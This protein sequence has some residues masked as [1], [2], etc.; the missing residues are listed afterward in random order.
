MQYTRGELRNAEKEFYFMP[1][2]CPTAGH[3]R[4]KSRGEGTWWTWAGKE[5]AHGGQRTDTWWTHTRETQE[6]YGI[7]RQLEA[8]PK[9]TRD[10][11]RAHGG[12]QAD[13]WRTNGKQGLE[14]GLRDT[15]RTQGERTKALDKVWRR[16]QAHSKADTRRKYGGYTWRTKCGDAAKA[17]SRR[18]Q[19]GQ[20][21]THRGQ[22][23]GT[24]PEHIAASPFLLREN[25]HSKLF[26]EW[27]QSGG[28]FPN[29]LDFIYFPK[30]DNTILQEL[31]KLCLARSA[32]DNSQS[33]NKL[34]GCCRIV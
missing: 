10:T 23:P 25:P 17:E 26:G 29:L 33:S 5:W 9:R 12:H 11:R 13:T 6:A 7:W 3:E 21:R 34:W 22:A 30:K 32:K 4:T 28:N 27:Q 2:P 1:R 24:R 14:T 18:T 19:G 15:R 20:W 8:R 31:R 16:S